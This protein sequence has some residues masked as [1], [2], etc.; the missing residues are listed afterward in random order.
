MPKGRLFA[1]T[2]DELL[3]SLALMRA[4]RRGRLD[5]VEIPERRSTSW[6]SR[7]WPRGLRRLGRGRVVRTVPPGVAVSRSWR[8]KISRRSSTC[9]AKGSPT[10]AA[11]RLSAP[12]S[13]SMA[14]CGPARARLAAITS[15]G[16]IPE[17]ADYRVVTE[18]DGTFVG[19]LDEDFAIESMAG[20][21]FLLGNT[22]WRIL[23]VR[24]GEV[25]GP[26]RRGAPPSIPFWL[27]EAPGRTLELSAEVS[28][29]RG[30]LA[31]RLQGERTGQRCRS[32]G[33]NPSA[34][35]RRWAA[36]QAMDY[37]EAQAG[38]HRPG[39]HREEIVFERFF[40]ESGGMQLVIHAP[41]GA[42]INRAW[43]LALAK[44]FCRSFDFELQAS[45][46][47]NGIVLSLGPQHSF[48][49]ENMFRM[50]NADNVDRS[51]GAGLAGRADVPSPLALERDA[52]A[53]RAA[54][55]RR[56]ERAAALAA[57]P[58]RRSAGGRV[59]G[60]CRLPGKPFRRHRDSRSSARP[61]ND[62]RLPA[63]G[64]G[65]RRAG[66]L[67]ER[68][69]SGEIDSW[70]ATRASRR[71]SATNCSMPTLT[72]FSTMLRWKNAVRGPSP[73]GARCRPRTL[74]DLARLD[75]EAI[76]QVRARS[77]AAGSRCR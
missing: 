23:H 71:R 3:E 55:A 8:E 42:R 43:G 56:Q 15:G 61:A 46:D 37:V 9:S 36:E 77:L 33:C 68:V 53:G 73:R 19:T 5:R 6:R 34:A 1:L 41:F 12:R 39:A 60:D 30:E 18:D 7:S 70:P 74:R 58:L 63:R 25:R 24:G 66:R 11:R 16:A 59:S 38:R 32:R 49:M 65:P 67:I 17:T 57:V 76:A 64:D 62:A 52:G 75:P 47:D 72:R 10:A 28:Q 69:R 21:V 13:R 20:D 54:P 48:P 45:A 14:G 4:V 44:A 40:D 2:R 29:L 50:L 31:T 35:R 51:A 27:G 22:S 26:R